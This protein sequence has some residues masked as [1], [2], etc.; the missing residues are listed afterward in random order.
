[1]QASD[2]IPSNSRASTKN[3]V[4]RYG[5]T[6]ALLILIVGGIAWVIQYLPSRGLKTPAAKVD[7]TDKRLLVFVRD[8]A[9]WGTRED[10]E[11]KQNSP[12][13]KDLEPGT[14]GHYDF[15]F[16]NDFGH[17]IVMDQFWNGCTCAEVKAG[18]L[19]A[20]E[21]ERLR[22][23]YL[24][25]PNE[26]LPYAPEPAWISLVSSKLPVVPGVKNESL[27]VKAGEGGVAR[28]EWSVRDNVGQALDVHPIVMF[29]LAN[30]PSQ[31][32]AH[33]LVV[34]IN[35]AAALQ[36]DPARLHVGVLSSDRPARG[37]FSVWSTTRDSLDIKP[38]LVHADPLFTFESRP[39]STQE[40]ADLEAAKKLA[41]PIRCAYQVSVTVHE[42]KNGKRLDQ[43]S[44]YRKTVFALDGN[45]VNPDSPL[46]GPEI[47]G[48]VDGGILI[49]G[50]QNPGKILFPSF[51]A[52]NGASQDVQLA[53]D[54]NLEL[55]KF[56]DHPDQPR[57]IK[58][59]LT[60]EPKQ[61]GGRAIWLLEVVVP[62]N[63][64]GA[65]SFD[66]PNAVVLKIA[67]T[68]ERLVRIPL[69][70]HISR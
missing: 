13:Y 34:P 43:G 7:A 58:V 47:V 69:E 1:M 37:H 36:F 8:V 53:A 23:I 64:P 12:K 40:R 62:P 14:K 44:F 41:S 38:M 50:A 17:D 29:H 6:L 22:K 3:A 31:K 26:L 33:R 65:T 5:L 63:A 57:W 18:V 4:L 10:E 20:E 56:D 66:E 25:K 19:P 11:G 27:L 45:P 52:K 46:Y 21:W 48:R 39:F 24:E 51:S 54:A 28:V 59:R 16:K 49:G 30:D 15:L 32:G 55:Q 70:G 2:R 68:P 60:R 67:G 42:S 61:T 9:Q 35:I